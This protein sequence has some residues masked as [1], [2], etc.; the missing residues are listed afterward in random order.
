MV[1]LLYWA[2]LGAVAVGRLPRAL[3]VVRQQRQAAAI[4][5]A[6]ST[7]SWAAGCG[8]RAA[9]HDDTSMFMKQF[10]GR[11]RTIQLR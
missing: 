9:S 10:A 7:S 5:I 1:P 4:M 11:I 6:L 8:L 3:T 2:T